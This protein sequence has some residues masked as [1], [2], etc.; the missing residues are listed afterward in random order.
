MKKS[1]LK[2]HKKT[3]FGKIL[4]GA[5]ALPFVRTILSIHLINNL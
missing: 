3:I 2:E 1:N 4:F 5:L